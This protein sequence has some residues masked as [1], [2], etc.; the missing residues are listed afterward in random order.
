[1]YGA[2]VRVAL[3]YI[4]PLALLGSIPAHELAKGF[5]PTLLAV[6]VVWCVAAL[7]LSRRFWRFAMRYYGSA[8][9]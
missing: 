6:G 3:T 1:M 7:F 2:G 9:S 5:D 8:S 4:F